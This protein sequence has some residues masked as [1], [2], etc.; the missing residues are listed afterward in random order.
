VLGVGIFEIPLQFDTYFGHLEEDVSLGALGGLNISITTLALIALYG[1]WIADASLHRRRSVLRPLFGI[2]MLL[3]LAINLLSVAVAA[4]PILSFFDLALLVQSY[5]LFFYIANRVQT[6]EDLLFCVLVFAAALLTQG[7]AMLFAMA[8][9]L[10]DE[11]IAFGPLLLAVDAGQ[12]HVGTMNSPNLAGSTL[13]MLWF[14][15]ATSLLVVRDKWTWRLILACTIAGLL[16]ILMT[17]SRGAILTIYVGSVIIAVGLVSRGW[18]PKWTIAVAMLIT[19]TSI[20][21][22]IALYDNRIKEGDGDSAAS[23]GNLSL[24]AMDAISERPLLG[25]GA[26]NCHLATQKFASQS[27]Y[28]GEWFYTTHNKYLL[29]WVETGIVGLIAFALVLGNGFGQ[30]LN[31]WRKRDPALSALALA[32]VAALAGQMLHMAVDIFNSRAQVQILWCTLGLVAAIY[33]ISNQESFS[34]MYNSKRMAAMN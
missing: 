28:R 26:G 13:S 6:R 32:F 10:D 2:P 21:P 3:Y 24:I 5:A 14:P 30:A 19:V 20:F 11:S 34:R 23:R 7:L 1:L 9:R 18:L 15:V 27:F 31:V 17:Q 33:Q 8:L 22:L 29:V 25:Y 16:A 4:V 12:R